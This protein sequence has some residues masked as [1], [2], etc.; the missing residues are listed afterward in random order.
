METESKMTP[1]VFLNKVLGGTALGVVIGLIP[2]AVLSGILKY[3]TQHSFSCNHYSN[4]SYY[5]ISYANY[6]WWFD[7]YS[8][9]V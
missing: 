9:R 4:C 1:K 3:F 7:C 8:I 6:H 2:N 5:S